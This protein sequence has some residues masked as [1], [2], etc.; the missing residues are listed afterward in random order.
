MLHTEG[1]EHR[2]LLGEDVRE[3]REQHRP[4]QDEPQETG[5]AY[6]IEKRRI[7]QAAADAAGLPSVP[8]I[9]LRISLSAGPILIADSVRLHYLAK[10]GGMNEDGWYTAMI[11]PWLTV[12]GAELADEGRLWVP[13]PQELIK[14]EFRPIMTADI[15]VDGEDY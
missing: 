7:E 9:D 12:N 5:N 10:F 15:A 8:G 14:V 13:K 1:H 2:R 11:L 3:V 4:H 6:L